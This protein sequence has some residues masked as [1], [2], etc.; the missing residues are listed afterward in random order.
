M[1]EAILTTT[2]WSEWLAEGDDS[3]K[4]EMLWRNV[5]KGLP[6]GAEKFSRGLEKIA[7]RPL[8][9]RPLGSIKIE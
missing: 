2:D 5:E 7:S 4:L 6:C 3:Q 8:H 9:Y 1:E